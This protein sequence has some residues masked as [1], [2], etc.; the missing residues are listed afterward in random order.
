[1]RAVTRRLTLNIGKAFSISRKTY[2]SQHGYRTNNFAKLCNQ[3]AI[4]YTI[5]RLALDSLVEWD[6][7]WQLPISVSKC[8][9]LHIENDTLCTPLCINGNVLPTVKTCHD[10]GVLI[11]SDLS[12]SVHTDSVVDK[13]HQRANAILR[14]F[15]THD[16]GL[17]TRAFTV[18]KCKKT[19]RFIITCKA[20]RS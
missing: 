2:V 7:T 20:H 5:H 4:D 18:Y 6:D 15:V 16:A 13:A 8:C 12:P 11:S 14:R 10:L 1:M 9:V 3:V 19:L 17:S